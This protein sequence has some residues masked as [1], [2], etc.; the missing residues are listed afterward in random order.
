MTR[1][2]GMTGVVR[3]AV[4]PGSFDPLHCGH[5][6]IVRRA[7]QLYDELVVAVLD[8]SLK[9]SKLFAPEARVEL[10]QEATL[11]LENVVVEMFSGLL[12]TFAKQRAAQVIV[13]SLRGAADLEYEAQMA[14]I[15]RRLYPE[16]ET[17]F[18]LAAPEW[19]YV[20]STRVRE[21]HGLGADVSDLV[22]S[23]T[24]KALQELK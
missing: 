5:L 10:L 24:L 12:V 16:S 4:Y 13:K 6:D 7:S 1:Y 17:V 15:N 21:L 19:S 20:S 9:G 8:N 23:A 18:L 11:E 22:P 3:R 2:E 14:H